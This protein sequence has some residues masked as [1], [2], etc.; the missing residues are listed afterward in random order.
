MFLL[1]LHT[2]VLEPDLDLSLRQAQRMRYLYASPPGQV[3]VEVELFL[4]LQG[5]IAGVGRPLP[6]CFAI[7]VNR[8]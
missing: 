7:G 6:F 5:L 4:Q 2:S 1:P 8:T 3:P